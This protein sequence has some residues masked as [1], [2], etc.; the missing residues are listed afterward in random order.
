MKNEQVMPKSQIES[1]GD[2]DFLSKES[3][4]GIYHISIGIED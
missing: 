1:Q 4:I 2:T 3:V